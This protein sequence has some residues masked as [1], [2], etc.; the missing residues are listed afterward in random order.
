MMVNPHLAAAIVTE[1]QREREQ[2][3]TRYRLARSA[4]PGHGDAVRQARLTASTT[5]ALPAGRASPGGD[6]PVRCVA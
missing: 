5:A 1:R 2:A 6:R 3:A 4:R